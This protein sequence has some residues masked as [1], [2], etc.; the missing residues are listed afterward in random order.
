M[1]GNDDGGRRKRARP[2]RTARDEQ[3]DHTDDADP[4]FVSAVKTLLT[5]AGK[6]EL[7]ASL[8][9]PKINAC[10]RRAAAEAGTPEF[11]DQFR[12]ALL[13][14]AAAASGGAGSPQP[15]PDPKA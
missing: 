3:P 10:L 13:R 12:Q 7:A 11:Y 15:G 1:T 6:H 14:D 5:R 8:D 2:K 9:L 4:E